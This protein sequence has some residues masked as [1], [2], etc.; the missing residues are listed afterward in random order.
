MKC[1]KDYLK[2]LLKDFNISAGSWPSVASDRTSWR[3]HI[4][5]GTITAEG[6]KVLK[7]EQ[8]L[9]ACKGRATST[10]VTT[11][12]HFCSTYLSS[13]IIKCT[14]V[15]KLQTVCHCHL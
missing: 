7:A 10:Y 3:Q 8:K 2:I 11:P 4:T 5:R 9:A 12:T 15:S 13:A 1:F 6:H 14:A